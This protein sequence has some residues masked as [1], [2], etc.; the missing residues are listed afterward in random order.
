MA[1]NPHFLSEMDVTPTLQLRDD[2]DFPHSGIFKALHLATK[3]TYIIKESA[4][5]FDITQATSG[6]FTQLQVKG[7]AGFRQGA[8]AQIGSGSGTTTNI[9]MNTSYNPGT[10]G[11]DVTPVSADVYLLMVAT[12]ANAIVLRGSNAVTNKLPEW[13]DGDIPIAVV[14]VAAS[15]ADSATDRPIQYLTTD[16]DDSSLSIGYASSNNY[17]EAM[18]IISDSDGDVTIEN[19]RDDKDVIFKVS[20]G[21]VSTEVMRFDASNGVVCIGGETNGEATLHIRNAHTSHGLI[22][23]S[24]E[25]SASSAPDITLYRNS[26]SPA[27]GDDIATLLFRGRNDNS[28]SVDYAQIIAE[29]DDASDGAEGG[30][31]RFKVYSAGTN[32]TWLDVNTGTTGAGL[33]NFNPN[34]VATLDFKVESDTYDIISVDASDNHISLGGNDSAKIGFYAATPIVTPVLDAAT[35]TAGAGTAATDAKVLLV[36]NALVALGLCNIA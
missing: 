30:Q 28:Q 22:V 27:D 19:F 23:E 21:G 32:T 10:G 15:S 8:Y 13:I 7:G 24:T 11:V 35:M 9:T 1:V 31:I 29:I 33:I 2:L 18:S 14:K 25:A 6:G 34:G 17:V 3:G 26:A 16:Q 12:A 4:T 36:A 5:D 20:D